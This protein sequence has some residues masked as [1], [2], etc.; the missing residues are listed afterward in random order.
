MPD[1]AF[2]LKFTDVMALF[3]EAYGRVWFIVLTMLI[4]GYAVSRWRAKSQQTSDGHTW[5]LQITLPS[6]GERTGWIILYGL[7]LLLRLPLLVRSLWYDEAFTAA[8]ANTPTL[9]DFSTA[10]SSDV[11]PPAHYLIVKLFVALFGDSEVVLRLPSLIAGLLLI[12]VVW[13]L[14]LVLTWDKGVAWTSAILIAVLPA[15]SYYSVEA[16][17]PMLLALAVC[18][19]LVGLLE[20]RLWLV[21]FVLYWVP[22]LH[23]T[24]VIYTGVI[25]ILSAYYLGTRAAKIIFLVS[26]SVIISGVLILAQSGDVANGFWLPDVNPTWHLIDMTVTLKTDNGIAALNVML[27]ITL[28]TLLS[29]WVAR[30]FLYHYWRGQVAAVIALVPLILWFIGEIWHPI[31]LQRAVIASTVIVVILWA[32]ALPRLHWLINLSFWCVVVFSIITAQHSYLIEKNV[33]VR[34]VF[35][36]CNGADYV[37]ATTTHMAINALYYAPAPLK[38]WRDGNSIAQELSTDAKQAMGLQ[39]VRGINDLPSG[40]WCMVVM[41][42]ANIRPAEITHV[43]Y[44]VRHNQIISDD[45]LQANPLMSYRIV[46]F[47][48]D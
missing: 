45:W 20:R 46:R 22:L 23:A 9:S 2:T 30:D 3:N 47:W 15:M 24:G 31:Y 29:V 44:I 4:V 10:L 13:R 33:S 41:Y 5:R 11:H 36:R 6:I 14:A 19:A 21:V 17:Y 1:H 38:A 7:A 16:R 28:L 18:T 48:H 27:V 37:Y 26:P 12:Y 39:L 42:E 43:N 34:D 25:L 32:Y 8:M 40:E 35:Q